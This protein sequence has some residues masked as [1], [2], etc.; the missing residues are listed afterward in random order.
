MVP[1]RTVYRWELR[2]LVSQK[3]TYLGLAAAIVVPIIFV[4]ALA[5]Q[6]GQPEDVAFGRYV[7]QSGLAIPPVILIFGSFWLFPLITALVSGDIV[8]AED[9]N[10]TLKTILTRSVGRGRIFVAKV[11]AA[12][13]YAMVALVAM[14]VTAIIGG[15]AKSGF[16]PL[17]TLSGTTVS[18][19]KA[20]GLIGASLLVYALPLIAVASIALLLSTVT[21]NSAAAVVGALMIS[22]LLQ[23]VTIIPGLGALQPYL[24][25]TQFNAWQGFLRTPA[26]WAPVVRA[27]W[28]CALYALPC[29]AVAY[30][31]FLRRDVAGG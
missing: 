3:R 14:G 8:A 26:D 30:L 10:G 22:L 18:A 25:P 7:R 1:L 12:L 28:V 15:V 29:L 11:L 21:H 23:L 16:H 5:L 24:L 20:L 6:S 27:A 4:V 17:V 31:S 19:W 2:K 9:H 13:T